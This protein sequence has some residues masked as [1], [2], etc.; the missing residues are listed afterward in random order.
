D[1]DMTYA[2][3]SDDRQHAVTYFERDAGSGRFFHYDRAAKRGRF[4]FPARPALDEVPLVSLEPVT[5]RA[6]DGFDLACYLSLPR[7]APPAKPRRAGLR[8]HGCPGSRDYWGS[9]PT[10]QWPADRGYAA[11]SV[12][13]RGSTG[14]GKAFVNAANLEWAGRMHDDLIDAVDWAVGAGIAE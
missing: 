3:W 1:G 4:L 11:L 12:N 13:Y 5:V 14:F 9:Q 6:R 2:G 7:H 10:H 8:V